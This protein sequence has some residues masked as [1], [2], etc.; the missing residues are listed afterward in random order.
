M[1]SIA[2]GDY[3]LE[4]SEQMKKRPMEPLI[5]MLREAGVKIECLEEEG[6]FP[7]DIHSNGI[8]ETVR[9]G[10]KQYTV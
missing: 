8:S 7:F 3:H 10:R 1:L 4:S 9:N 6:H 2:G 5:T